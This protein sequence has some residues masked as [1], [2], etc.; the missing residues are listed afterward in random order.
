MNMDAHVSMKPGPYH[1]LNQSHA[2]LLMLYVG[3]VQADGD[4]HLV[5]YGKGV[6]LHLQSGTLGA[7]S[8]G[9]VFQHKASM[10]SSRD[11]AGSSPLHQK[12]DL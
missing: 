8:R 6:L 7:Q 3:V 2:D 11:E 4:L 12:R 5:K 1:G 10:S 9:D